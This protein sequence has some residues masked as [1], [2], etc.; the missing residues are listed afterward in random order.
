MKFLPS[1]DIERSRVVGATVAALLSLHSALPDEARV[2][3]LAIGEPA[4]DFVLP[5]VDGK[6]HGAR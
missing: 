4:P 5:G 1:L 6:N 3:P 2:E